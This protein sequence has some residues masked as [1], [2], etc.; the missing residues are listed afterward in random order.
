MFLLIFL[1]VIVERCKE[2][3]RM[4]RSDVNTIESFSRL[5]AEM[6]G[7]PI[8]YP[9]P[10]SFRNEMHEHDWNNGYFSKSCGAT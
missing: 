2:E 9:L 1:L 4:M 6:G 8:F 5:N 3:K 10:F 7:L